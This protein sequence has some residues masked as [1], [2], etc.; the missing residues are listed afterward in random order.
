MKILVATRNEHKLK[1]FINLLKP[2]SFT[3]INPDQV[4]TIP[5]NFDVP[6][7]G[8]TFKQNAVLKA[9][10]FGQL[11]NFLT[12]ADDSGFTIDHLNGKPGI[13][14]SRFAKGDFKQARIRILQLLKAVSKS[15]R[16]AQFRCALALYNP[17]TKQT[18]TFIGISHGHISYK[19][20]GTSGFGYDSIFMP[21][22]T[23]K[24]YAEIPENQ[25]N[26]I[27]H[28][29]LAFKKLVNY[30]KIHHHDRSKTKKVS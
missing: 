4:K 20:K 15:N 2:L 22:D 16:T 9:N 10:G 1:E 27:S 29:G 3:I 17:K 26:Q 5:K 8:T 11:T 18:K 13:Y 28:R 23:G 7:T 21:N 24:T 14:S 30:L 19:E 12:L 6:E 25:K